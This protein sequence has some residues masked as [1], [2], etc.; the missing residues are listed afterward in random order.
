MRRMRFALRS[1]AKAPLLSLVVV[2]SLGLGIGVNTA[3]F[4]LL[5]QVVL[6]ALP[7]P[8][9]EQLVLLTAPG[10]FK[11]GRTSDNDSGG[12]DYI[13]NWRTFR[14]LEKHTEAAAV[15]GF[16]TFNSNIAFS[17]QTIS[18]SMML[19]SGR[20]FS[21]VG[22]RPFA[23]RVIA[24]EDDIP[25]GGNPI[26]V[27]GYRYWRDKLG[28]DTAV[29]NQTI[30]VNGQPFTIAGIAPPDFNGTTVGAEP[31]V[32]L[33]MSFK[34]HLTEG[35]DG[36]ERLTDY[37]VYLLA[38]LQPGVT[39]QQAEAA[40]NGP[41]RT[42]V[43]E[44]AST[45]S[46]PIERSTRFRQQKLSLKDGSHG[47]SGFRDDY[48]SALKILFLATGLVLLIAMANAA[49][50]LLARSAERRKELAIRAALG[51]S[52][53]EL[54][55]QFLTE[56][57]LMACAG[58]LAGLAIAGATL[59]LLI[60]SWS[61]G[62]QDSFAA[63]GLNWP[64]LWFSLGVTLATGLLF[65]LY[66]AWDATRSSLSTTL[67]DES[68][69]ASS[70]RGGVRLRKTLVSLQVTIS[71]VLLVPT[72][73]FLKSLVNLLRVD[74]GIRT[75]NVIG[76]R[77]T[78]QSNGYT[79]AQS[80]AVF[81]RAEVELAAIPGVR[82]AVGSSVPLIGSSNWGTSFSIEGAPADAGRPNSKYNEVGPEFF[83][84]AGIPL[85]AGREIRESDTATAPKI[86][87]VNEA[88]VRQFFEG[89]NPIGHR[90]G[91]G[92]NGGLD[93]EIVGVVKDSHYSGVRQPPPPLF[94]R[95]WRQDDRL[96]S[97]SFYLRSDLPAKQIIPQIRRVLS[98]IDSN[99]PIEDLRTLEE[100]VHY[101]IRSDELIMR[102]AAAFAVLATSLAMLGLYGVMAHGV[103]RRT[104]EIGIRMAL[105]AAP[106]R[107][108]AMV[109]R[110]LVWIL[111]FGLGLGI[112]AAVAS[113]R[114]IESRLF[115]VH[116][117]DPAIVGSVALLLALTAAAAAYW[118][119]RRASCVDP[120][121]ALRC[122]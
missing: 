95:P 89:R 109:M 18:G 24:P 78:P 45:I 16:R 113:T 4:S 51:A 69:K 75:A 11:N 98:S 29:L 101:N 6:S 12:R 33:P 83:S 111:G 3:I 36:T 117:K 28:G 61:G 38:R 81:E 10:E 1:L 115:G 42:I 52:R 59:K 70:S 79:P 34:P 99:V 25:G 19:V 44:M 80:R 118:P 107:I 14:E 32:Y 62:A 22:A 114:L 55:A 9:P 86:V 112:P 17:R 7:I 106:R 92:R 31:S 120:L 35:W 110:E 54:I 66:P 97:I 88:F 23:G 57:L 27:L 74:L 26:A 108:R 105:G 46:M 48:R 67:G 73:L 37:W 21:I 121:D 103:A 119:A 13:F 20:Y 71:I 43:E 5:H 39:A 72:G 122:E 68:A 53:V 58:G 100:Q 104:R 15:A 84:K 76:F 77:I 85:I 40:L 49:N 90:I 96:G 91:F 87:V 102:L 64:V 50:L 116:G 41:Y 63:T 56:A 30:K 94:F 93:T 82:S 2:L 60:A 8:H 47:N 65:G